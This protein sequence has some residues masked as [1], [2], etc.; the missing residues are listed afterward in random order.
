MLHFECKSTPFKEPSMRILCQ[1]HE[2]PAGQSF[3]RAYL[4]STEL[5]LRTRPKRQASLPA[6]VG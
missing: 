1:T 3:Y 6:L 2:W 4:Q 5:E